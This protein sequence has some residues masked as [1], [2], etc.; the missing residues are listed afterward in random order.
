MIA[1]Y[2]NARTDFLHVGYRKRSDSAR[3]RPNLGGRLPTGKNYI[4]KSVKSQN[5]FLRES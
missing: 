2:R 3:L 4:I 1:V 5:V